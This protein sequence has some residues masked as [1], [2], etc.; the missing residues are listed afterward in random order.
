MYDYTKPVQISTKLERKKGQ[1]TEDDNLA[2][3]GSR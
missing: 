2:L 1:P 3:M